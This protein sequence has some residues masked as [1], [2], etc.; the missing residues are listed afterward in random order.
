M[1]GYPFNELADMNR[2]YGCE[3][4]NGR[5]AERLCQV[6]FP[7]QRHPNDK[8]FTAIDCGF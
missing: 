8:T 3:S 6:R 2:M 5:R 4:G 1:D 7:Y